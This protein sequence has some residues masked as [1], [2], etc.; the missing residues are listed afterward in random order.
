MG[1][2]CQE[3]CTRL[4]QAALC[5][6]QHHTHTHTRSGTSLPDLHA[7]AISRWLAAAHLAALHLCSIDGLHGA[8]LKLAPKGLL[9]RVVLQPGKQRN[10]AKRMKGCVMLCYA[11][12]PTRVASIPL[13]VPSTPSKSSKHRADANTS[14]LL[15][16]AL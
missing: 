5:R 2:A 7:A 14:V 1:W 13:R 3:A 11:V 6:T 10:K 8:V 12:C 16:L 9:H 4:A 15:M